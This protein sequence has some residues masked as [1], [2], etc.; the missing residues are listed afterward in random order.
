MWQHD[1]AMKQ[2]FFGSKYLSESTGRL[3]KQA[4]CPD[5]HGSVLAYYINQDNLLFGA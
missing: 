2:I 1:F 4:G 5:T 3:D